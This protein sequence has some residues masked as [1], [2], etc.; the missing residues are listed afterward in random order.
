M[1]LFGKAK[2]IVANEERE[3]DKRLSPDLFQ[4]QADSG[5]KAEEAAPIPEEPAGPEEPTDVM[6]FIKIASLVQQELA[7]KRVMPSSL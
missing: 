2:E 7:V 5:R 6:P 1:V 4:N 3:K